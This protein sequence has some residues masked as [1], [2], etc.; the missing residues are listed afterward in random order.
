[1]EGSLSLNVD[2]E[3]TL[4]LY[5]KVHGQYRP[6]T[7]FL[8]CEDGRIGIGINIIGKPHRDDV[9][10]G[11][12]NGR[13]VTVDVK[14]V[15]AFNRTFCIDGPAADTVAEPTE[16][17][18]DTNIRDKPNNNMAVEID[19]ELFKKEP[20]AVAE[21]DQTDLP[22]AKPER[23]LVSSGIIAQQLQRARDQVRSLANQLKTVSTAATE[24]DKQLKGQLK[25]ANHRIGVLQEQLD[26]EIR[27]A[28]ENDRQLRQQITDQH[29]ELDRLRFLEKQY[30]D[31]VSFFSR[32]TA[33][34]KDAN[35]RAACQVRIKDTEDTIRARTEVRLR[36]E[37][38]GLVEAVKQIEQKRKN[39]QGSRIYYQELVQAIRMHF[40]EGCRN[41]S[42]CN[43]DE[44]P[45]F[46][47]VAVRI[48]RQN[49]LAEEIEK[50][51]AHHGMGR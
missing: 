49:G 16:P 7:V 43:T 20:V 46:V 35:A 10:I 26:L 6:T 12:E 8:S 37:V 19:K 45:D 21:M 11:I 44:L 41:A 4:H 14:P 2:D 40:V 27:V 36:C 22:K 18:I 31:V 9:G 48:A 13:L 1:M 33:A 24:S 28:A 5:H 39:E 30:R 42:G 25:A 29:E 50:V 34:A 15:H 17:V 38:Q 32:D 51:K 3:I 23:I 47:K